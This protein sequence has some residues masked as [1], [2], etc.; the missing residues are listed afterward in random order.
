MINS[1]S[2]TKTNLKINRV[3]MQYPYALLNKLT[4]FLLILT[5]AVFTILVKL[6]LW[7]L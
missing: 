5:V 2:R 7:Q 4:V 3:F 6:G 1:N